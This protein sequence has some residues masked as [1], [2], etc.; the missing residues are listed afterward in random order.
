MIG[1]GRIGGV[2]NTT[3]NDP[4][5]TGRCWNDSKE[6]MLDMILLGLADVMVSSKY[7]SF[8]FMSKSIAYASG[9]PH[10]DVKEYGEDVGYQCIT[11]VD[12]KPLVQTELAK[13][14]KKGSGL[15]KW[16]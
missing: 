14:P 3:M 11:H 6:G 4:Q 7:S 13:F 16:I 12:G 15:G 8:T 1:A 10:C 5:R 9:R 2:K